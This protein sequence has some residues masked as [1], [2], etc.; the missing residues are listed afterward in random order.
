MA[1]A[2]A[3]DILGPVVVK[4]DAVL[5]AAYDTLFGPQRDCVVPVYNFLIGKDGDVADFGPRDTPNACTGPLEDAINEELAGL[6]ANMRFAKQRNQQLSYAVVVGHVFSKH[7]DGWGAYFRQK[8]ENGEFQSSDTFSCDIQGVDFQVRPNGSIANANLM[9]GKGSRCMYR[10]LD[11]FEAGLM[12]GGQAIRSA[13]PASY[14]VRL[15]HKVLWR[16]KVDP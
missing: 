11:A 3:D 15:N 9:G 8:R 13:V 1:S 14:T 12:A 10:T 6:F 4:S 7:R 2:R 16:V 5:N